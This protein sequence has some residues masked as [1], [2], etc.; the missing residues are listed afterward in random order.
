MSD[1]TRP[2]VRPPEHLAGEVTLRAIGPDD[3]RLEQQLSHDPDVVAWTHY[4]SDMDETQARQRI[5]RTRQHALLGAMQR[6]VVLD[7]AAQPLG[8]CG[9]TK[10]DTEAPEVFYVLLPGA[11]GH[12]AATHAVVALTEWVLA[13]GYRQ[14]VIET[15][16]GNS[17]SERVAQRA[18]FGPA[19][20]REAEQRGD[21]VVVR[22][23]VRIAAQASD[24][25]PGRG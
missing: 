20:R 3:W 9:I 11:R 23:W 12:G 18:G 21:R 4:P 24:A 15:I 10:L 19:G 2:S 16:V 25:R 6:Y 14:V 13:Q 8:T 17:A 1:T 5:D 7:Q 22:R